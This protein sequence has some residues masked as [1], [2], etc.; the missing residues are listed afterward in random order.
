MSTEVAVVVQRL[1]T[2]AEAAA[3]PAHAAVLQATVQT[4]AAA[5]P[6]LKVHLTGPLEAPNQTEVM[7]NPKGAEALAQ[8]APTGAEVLHT[9]TRV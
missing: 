5:D 3:L 9:L 6:A 4:E 1:Q 2:E 8:Q 7:L